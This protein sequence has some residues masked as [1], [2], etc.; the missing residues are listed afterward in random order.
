MFTKIKFTTYTIKEH[1]RTFHTQVTFPEKIF[2][3]GIPTT[4]NKEQSYRI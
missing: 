2:Y 1:G 3:T 4:K